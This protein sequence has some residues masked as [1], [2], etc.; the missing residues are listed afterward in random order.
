MRAL[1]WFRADLRVTDNTALYHACKGA[2]DGVLAVFALCPKQWSQHDW[3]STKVE[4]LLR[5]LAALSESLTK[6][7]IPLTLIQTGSFSSVPAKL[8]QIAKKHNCDALFFN[9]EYEVNELD[10]DREVSRRFAKEKIRV[11]E[12]TDQVIVDVGEIRTGKGDWYTVYTPFRRKWC[13]AL[14]DLGPPQLW[15]K[16]RRQAALGIKSDPIPSKLSGFIRGSRA[17]LWPAGEKEAAKRLRRF[18]KERIERYQEDRNFPA[19][20]GTSTLSPYLSAGVL[21]PRQCLEGAIAANNGQVNSGHPGASTWINEL[22]WREFYRHILMGYPHV[23]K[24]QPFKL[25]TEK[26]P[27]RKDHKQFEAWCTGKTGFPMVDAAMRQLVQT[28]WMHNRLRM[29]VSMFLSKDLFIDWRWGERFFM[30]HLVDGDFA[31]N[32]GGWQ[33]SASTGTDAA[34]YFRI[35][36][37][38]NQ[39]RKFDPQAVFIKRFVPEL[40]GLGDIDLHEPPHNRLPEGA[41]PEPIVDRTASRVRVLSAFQ[42]LAKPKPGR[43]LCRGVR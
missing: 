21:S 2:N 3:G 23:C 37:P 18:I 5:N 34:P 19:V 24:R 40:A 28:G 39:S 13:A 36:N 38:Y 31:S 30:Q 1:I 11:C 35:F 22:I 29:V 9:R 4:F 16:P 6:L 20:D 17:D 26:L 32:N 33:W 7:N 27:W 43:G 14:E 15:P 25:E 41:Y 42:K 12:F 10:R 8:V